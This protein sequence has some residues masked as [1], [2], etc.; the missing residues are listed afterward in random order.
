M[1]I[2]T[3]EVGGDVQLPGCLCGIRQ[4][5]GAAVD[6]GGLADKVERLGRLRVCCNVTSEASSSLVLSCCSTQ[7]NWTSC[8]VNWLVSSGSSG[9]WFCSWVVSIGRKVWKLPAMPVF[10][11][12]G[13]FSM[14]RRGKGLVVPETTGSP[15][16][17]DLSVIIDLL[18][19]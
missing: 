12:H 1:L 5:R 3:V 6:H 10:E 7:A 16:F 18:I 8:W 2:V 11:A 19:L 13:A 4:R 14:S 17:V 9:F 15:A